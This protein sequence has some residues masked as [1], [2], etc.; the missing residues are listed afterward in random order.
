MNPPLFLPLVSWREVHRR[1]QLIFP[2]GTSNR[3]YVTREMAAKTI[4][5]LLYV[6]AVGEEGSRANPKHVVNMTD[7]QAALG[8]AAQ[9]SSFLTEV[10][11]PKFQPSGTTW[12][13]MNTREPIRDETLKEGLWQFDAARA[14]PSIPANSPKPRHYLTE[15]FAALFSPLFDDEAL[16]GGIATWQE[17]HLSPTALKRIRIIAAANSEDSKVSVSVPGGGTRLLEPGPTRPI[18][19]GFLEIFVPRFFNRPHVIWLSQS[20]QKAVVADA[21]FAKK[22]G[23]KIDAQKVLPDLILAETQP[24]LLL[25]FVEFVATSGVINPNR[26][27]ALLQI[28]LDAGLRQQDVAFVTAY[29]DRGKAPFTSTFSELAWNSFA[30]CAAEPECLIAVFDEQRPPDLKLSALVKL[31]GPHK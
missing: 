23:L 21:A 17:A 14:D 11:V 1:L 27:A 16:R 3:N 18:A 9:R 8:S 31:I 22:I 19:K 7:R 30:W 13:A 12:F 28:A 15:D 26:R 2:E 5:V 25:V 29:L 24:E 10:L 20:G 4:Y 6:G